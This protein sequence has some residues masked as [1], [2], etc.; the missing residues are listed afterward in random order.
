MQDEAGSTL[1]LLDK[2]HKIQKTYH[3]DAFGII[4]KETGSDGELSNRLT[5]T[6]QI[7][8]GATGQ[9]YLRARFY[10][11][12]IGRFMQE[13][14][15]RGD[16]LNLYAYCAN[17]PVM[18]Y[19]PSGYT[20]LC[21]NRKTDPGTSPNEIRKID[22]DII[23]VMDANGGHIQQKHVGKSNEFL[24]RRAAQENTAATS[25]L[26]KRTAI[27]TVQQNIRQ[28]A[29]I[30]SDWLNN[31]NAN[32]F[33]TI[34]GIHKYSIGYG[35][36]VNSYGTVAKNVTYGLTNSKIFMVKDLSMPNGYR[37]ITAYPTFN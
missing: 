9:Y 10:H 2:D 21:L 22:D 3:Y 19:D 36:N 16:G 8:D 15:Y 25:F 7:I 30:I 37:I 35:V 23:D 31:P 1:F 27:D 12:E 6:G 24:L 11:P 17:N 4:L 29:D 20:Q 34:D 18:Y 33:L 14:V 26:D 32:G 28:N 5:Y 13:D